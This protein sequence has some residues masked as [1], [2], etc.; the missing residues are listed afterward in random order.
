MLAFVRVKHPHN[1]EEYADALLDAVVD[2]DVGLTTKIWAITADNHEVNPCLIRRFGS[3]VSEMIGELEGDSLAE[4]AP[5]PRM[6][7]PSPPTDEDGEGE[8]EWLFEEYNYIR[9]MSHILHLG[10]KAGREACYAIDGA[11]GKRLPTL[12]LSQNE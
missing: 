11:A 7:G 2:V 4:D 1:A 8:R 9:C 10:V 12:L 3:R 5:V 6:R